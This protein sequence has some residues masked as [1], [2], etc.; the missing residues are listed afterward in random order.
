VLQGPGSDPVLW[1]YLP[2]GP[3]AERAASTVG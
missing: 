3:F 1:D 2:Y